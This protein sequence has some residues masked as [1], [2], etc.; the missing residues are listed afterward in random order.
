MIC[1]RNAF[2]SLGPACEYLLDLLG[3]KTV[4]ERVDQRREETVEESGDDT[5]VGGHRQVRE[6]RC[7]V[8]KETRYVVDR[9]DTALGGAGGEGLHSALRRT[10]SGLKRR[11]NNKIKR[12]KT[13]QS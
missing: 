9:N 1:R 5:L 3:S 13:C 12:Q 4:D 10:G 7:G 2:S 6:E 11:V 8:D